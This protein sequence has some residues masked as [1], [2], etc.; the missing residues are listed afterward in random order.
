MPHGRFLIVTWD[1][2]GNFPPALAI[3][4]RLAREGHD[5]RVLASRSLRDRV[6]AARLPFEGFQQG[7]EWGSHLGRGFDGEYMQALQCGTGIAA[8]LESELARRQEDV[9]VVDFMLWGALAAAERSGLPTAGLVHTLYQPNRLGLPGAIWEDDEVPIINATRGG[10]GLPL[11]QSGRELWDRL[12]MVLVL[13]PQAF[14]L[15]AAEV[16]PNVHHVGPVFDE[17]TTMA[18]SL[19]WPPDDREPLVLVSFST[20]YMRQEAVVQRVADAVAQ[21]PVRALVTVGDGILTRGLTATAQIAIRAYADHQVVLPHTAAVVTH[22]GHST[23]MAALKH[24]V[25]L[26]CMPMGRDQFANAERVEACGAGR[27]IDKDAAVEDIRAALIEVLDRPAYRTGARRMAEIIG[28]DANGDRV[29]PL[30][31]RLLV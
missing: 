25:P 15:P 12:A 23:V 2:G 5:V 21:L 3:G 22:A 17:P 14:D 18:W 1:G 31:E 16:Q 20:T 13:T 24:G 8:D 10:L 9:L 6:E 4:R 26:L 7:P 11:L 29:V 19:P 30:L 27:T 28:R